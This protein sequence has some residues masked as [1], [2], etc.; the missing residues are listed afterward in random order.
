MAEGDGGLW[1][2]RERGRGRRNGGRALEKGNVRKEEKELFTTFCE[3]EWTG[4]K[5]GKGV[6]GSEG[7]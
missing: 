1:K 6:R 2:D 7:A 5:V 4:M 3:E